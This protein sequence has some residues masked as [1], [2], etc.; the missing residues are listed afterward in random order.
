[1]NALREDLSAAAAVVQRDLRIMLSYRTRFVTTL[2]SLFFSLILF[3]FISRLVR[4]SS[5]PTPDAYYAFAVVGLITLQVLN[6]TLHAP[7]GALRQE[8]TTG[9]FE[10]FVLSPMGAVRGMLALMVFP[11]MYALVIA[12]LMLVFAALLFGVHLEWATLPLIV[13]VGLLGALSFAPFGVLF[14]ACVLLAKQAVGG[15]TFVVAGISL[16]AG[17]YF[18]VSLLPAWIRWS[19]DVQPFTPAVDL[20]RHVLVGTHLHDA[21]AT[22]LAKLVGFTTVLLPLSIW[23]LAGAL[24]VSRRRGTVLEY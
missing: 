4:V 19:T 8:Q 24:R 11:F 16:I 20:M 10:R 2:V 12:V 14:L 17:M 23:A 1:V 7:P 9:N 15:A 13:P 18:P 5:F 22:E 21:L 3:H 6:S